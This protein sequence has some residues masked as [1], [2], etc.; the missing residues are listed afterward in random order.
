MIVDLHCHTRHGSSCSYMSPEDMVEKA[1]KVGLAGLC[2]TEHEIP[3]DRDATRRLSDKFGIL[4]IGGMEVST[5]YGEV[6]VLGLD[7]PIFDVQDI[8][9]LRGRVDRAEGVMVAAHPFRG[10]HGLV[11]WD[12]TDGV[13]LNLEEAMRRPIFEVVDA[14]EVFNGMATEWEIDLCSAVCDNLPIMGAA[15]S[16]AHNVESVGD[17]VTILDNKVDSEEAFL[18]E[19]RQRRY[20]AHCRVR[21]RFYPN[22]GAAHFLSES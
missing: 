12:S 7:E 21:N 15:G 17:C 2:I 9:D 22:N 18:Q 3:W 4:V 8:H 1:V 14:I 20:L 5:A 10:A 11:R 19:M 13:V 6:L 16:D